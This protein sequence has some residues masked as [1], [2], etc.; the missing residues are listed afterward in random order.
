M[1]KVLGANVRRLREE[2]DWT[3]EELGVKVGIGRGAVSDIERSVVDPAFGTVQ[4][5]A[6][7]MDVRICELTGSPHPVQPQLG[8]DALQIAEV[9]ESLG[10]LDRLAVKQLFAAFAAAH[11]SR[12]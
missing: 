1:S 3:Q 9:F 8:P 5:I 10:D 2:R 12:H 7:V 4:A 11:A 6:D